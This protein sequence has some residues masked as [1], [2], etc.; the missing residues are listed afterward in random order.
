M[1]ELVWSIDPDRIEWSY[2]SSVSGRVEE[3]FNEEEAIAAMLLN[4]VVFMNTPWYRKDLSEEDKSFGRLIVVCNDVFAWG[5]ADAEPLPHDELHNLYKM[6][7]KDP[8]W[9]A[10]VW[11]IQ[12]RK[13]MPQ[14]PVEKLIRAGGIWDLDTMGLAQNTT[15]AHVAG[16]FN[17]MK[18]N[19]PSPSPEGTN[20]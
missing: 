14:K 20:G 13:E 2:E 5:C 15:D 8:A 9:G 19:P 11:C 16:L 12:R 6:W 3:V 7:R 10:E 17:A 4:E 18:G 1:T